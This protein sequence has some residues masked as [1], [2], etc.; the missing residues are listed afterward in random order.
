MGRY[1]YCSAGRPSELSGWSQDKSGTG[2]GRAG[3]GK[4]I[5]L[6]VADGPPVRG[7]DGQSQTVGVGKHD[8]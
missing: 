8:E 4:V 6:V 1:E 2:W 7:C 5:Q 3:P